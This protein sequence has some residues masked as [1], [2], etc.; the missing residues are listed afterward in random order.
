VWFHNTLTEFDFLLAPNES[1]VKYYEGI[2]G[3]KTFVNPTLMITDFVK[4]T[5][6]KLRDNTIIG[7]NFVRWYG[8]FDSYIV[9]SEF[10]KSIYAPSMGRKQT[11]EEQLEINHLP[12]FLWIDWMYE[13]SKF[14]YAVHLMPTHAAGTFALNCAYLGIPC[15]GYEG[16][17]TQE[18]CFPELTIKGGDISYARYLARKL[19]DNKWFYNQI[20]ESAKRNYDRYFSEQIYLKHWNEIWKKLHL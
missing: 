17:D 12:Y 6:K 9:A 15:I 14:K 20:A 1:D 18:K 2:T 7:G 16:L 11:N 8:G 19:K 13:L 5:K 3:L 4:Q 10:D